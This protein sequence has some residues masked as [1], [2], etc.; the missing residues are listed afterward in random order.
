M[1]E[2]PSTA[3]GRPSDADGR[4]S[5]VSPTQLKVAAGLLFGAI[6]IGVLALTVFS[7]PGTPTKPDNKVSII[8][9]PNQGVAPENGGDR[10]GWEQLALLGT[11]IVV[12]AGIGVIAVR[13]RGTARPGRAAWEAAG[14]SDHDGAVAG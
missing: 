11:I 1:A 8:P 6:L 4:G 13:G 3:A 14:A 2:T 5:N 7:D 12:V 9:Q 10:G